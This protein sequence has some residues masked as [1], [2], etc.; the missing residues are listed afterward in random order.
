MFVVCWPNPRG[1]INP[2]LTAFIANESVPETWTV[3]AEDSKRFSTYEEA[4]TA[5]FEFVV[6]NPALIGKVKVMGFWEN[7]K[8]YGMWEEPGVRSDVEG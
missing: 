4:S 5:A 6:K 7:G 2:N 1:Q 8:S 3:R